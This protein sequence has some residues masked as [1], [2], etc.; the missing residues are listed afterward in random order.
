MLIDSRYLCC[1]FIVRADAQTAELLDKYTCIIICFILVQYFFNISFRSTEISLNM[2]ST[3][4][5]YL[6]I[7]K[8]KLLRRRVK[9]YCTQ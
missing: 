6:T 5:I 9:N 3:Q 1:N 7:R 2:A 4:N 8:T